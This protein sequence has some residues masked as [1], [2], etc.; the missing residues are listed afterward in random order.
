MSFLTEPISIIALITG[1]QRSIAGISAY[2]T[3]KEETT[4][5][6]TITKQPVQQ[7]ASITDHSYMEPV[8]FSA[9]I[10]MKDNFSVSLKELYEEIRE[11]QRSREPFTVQTPKRTY[12]NMLIATLGQTTDPK[13][14]NVLALTVGFE[15][16]IIVDVGVVEVP[17]SKQ[18]LPGVTGQTQ[19][20]G[21]KSAL[22]TLA[23]P[24]LNFFG[25]R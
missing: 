4:D 20:V 2:L 24:V 10:Q 6:L 21:R 9:S 18:K 16:V 7:G 17:R 19:K 14:E 22:S 12:E 23:A 11:L 3:L 1:R 8:T 5:R 25:G 15:E 13:T